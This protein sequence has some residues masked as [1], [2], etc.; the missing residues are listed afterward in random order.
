ML[1]EGQPQP[2]C[3]KPVPDRVAVIVLGD[4][5]TAQSGRHHPNGVTVAKLARND[6]HRISIP[7]RYRGRSDNAGPTLSLRTVGLGY[8]AKT[9]SAGWP[10]ILI[11]LPTLSV[12]VLIGVTVPE[13]LLTT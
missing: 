7:G 6:G 2:K 12:A 4:E 11:A 8:G 13:R 5:L 10:S 9:M 3:R 1:G